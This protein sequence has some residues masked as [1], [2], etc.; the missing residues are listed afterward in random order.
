MPRGRSRSRGAAAASLAAL[1]WAVLLSVL[2]ASVE[3]ASL[4]DASA[5]EYFQNDFYGAL[6]LRFDDAPSAQEIKR[7]YRQLSRDLHPDRNPDASADRFQEIVRAKEVLT[8]VA[9]REDYD[10]FIKGLPRGFRPVYGHER[11]AFRV[12]KSD[13]TVVIFGG[14]LFFLAAIS[15]LQRAQWRRER[16]RA[17]SSD[18]FKD[19]MIAA[20]SRGVSEDDFMK[21][22]L[23]ANP[24]FSRSWADTVGASMLRAILA[25]CRVQPRAL[26][27]TNLPKRQFHKGGDS[28]DDA[29]HSA[30][31]AKAQDPE[32]VLQQEKLEAERLERSRRKKQADEKRRTQRR[33][34]MRQ[35]RLG[36]LNAEFDTDV[37]LVMLDLGVDSLVLIWRDQGIMGPK[38]DANIT[39]DDLERKGKDGCSLLHTL[40]ESLREMLSPTSDLDLP[41]AFWVH[42]F[43]EAFRVVAEERLDAQ[44]Q[45]QEA[46]MAAE[47]DRIRKL[48]EDEYFTQTTP[49]SDENAPLES[50]SGNVLQES[51]NSVEA[52]D[53]WGR[54]LAE[55]DR[56]SVEPESTGHLVHLRD[57]DG[58]IST[59]LPPWAA[60]AAAAL[61][62]LVLHVLLSAASGWQQARWDEDAAP[63][64]FTLRSGLENSDS[65]LA[66]CEELPR[67]GAP[68]GG[69]HAVGPTQALQAWLEV[70]ELLKARFG[71]E[72]VVVAAAQQVVAGLNRRVTIRDPIIESIGWQ[73][74][75]YVPL[76]GSPEQVRFTRCR[77]Q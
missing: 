71:R 69:W 41:E 22:F 27:P 35:Q 61:G 44:E 56:C 42:V 37:A 75:Y 73:L 46:R 32:D 66:P 72:M 60:C 10:G 3:S 77:L 68:M 39:R 24:E 58:R 62:L 51:S 29:D 31:D 19:Q 8:D 28:E 63:A 16:A 48:Q 9:L 55:R 5:Y 25:L 54:E 53:E 76:Q 59:W 50:S 52:D 12:S 70:N 40:R 45:E 36:R 65:L 1:A 33:E 6:G 21:A 26:R 13:P 7:A 14:F 15:F 43:D 64:K 11:A 57:A 20:G 74:A 4:Y 17:T 49:S 23:E 2:V 30:D 38:V 47:R 18:F 34:G 67:V